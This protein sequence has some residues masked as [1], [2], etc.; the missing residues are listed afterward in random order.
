MNKLGEKGLFT[1]ETM[2]KLRAE[3]KG[4]KG[5]IN[6]MTAKLAELEAEKEILRQ[7][8]TV[9]SGLTPEI[10]Q[11]KSEIEGK[12]DVSNKT[13]SLKHVRPEGEEEEETKPAKKKRATKAK[14]K[15]EASVEE[16]EEDVKP[17]KKSRAS[18]AKVKAEA[19]ED[20]GEK[21]LAKKQ[22][23]P[24]KG[25]V[26]Q[27]ATQDEA[28]PAAKPTRK[29]RVKKEIKN[30]TTDDEQVG[31]LVHDHIVILLRLSTDA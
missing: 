1:K 19:S 27:E 16:D 17:V 10:E 24:A 30:E 15:K 22:R 4:R 5:E 11:L 14:V 3:A 23:A 31:L 21:K 25:K 20:E 8:G 28:P 7:G 12:P 18:K 2:K 13:A 9:R 6:E 26:K 29:A